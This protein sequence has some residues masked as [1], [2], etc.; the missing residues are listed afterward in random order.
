MFER[1]QQQAA[2]RAVERPLEQVAGQFPQ[3]GSR[4]LA[5]PEDMRFFPRIADDQLLGRA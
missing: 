2:R 3:N 1:V 5:V 4:L